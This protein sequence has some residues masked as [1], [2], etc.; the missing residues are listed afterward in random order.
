[1]RGTSDI[2]FDVYV[3]MEDPAVDI[4]V[5]RVDERV[6]VNIGGSQ[7]T[8]TASC[9]RLWFKKSETAVDIGNQLIA[10]GEQLATL[11]QAGDAMKG[12]V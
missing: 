8:D 9:L 2:T 5:E 4:T 3:E 1:V 10:A 7:M 6:A 11:R 12:S